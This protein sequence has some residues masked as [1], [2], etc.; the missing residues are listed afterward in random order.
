MILVDGKQ[1][2][3]ALA[4]TFLTSVESP[5]PPRGLYN[6]IAG[7]DTNHLHFREL[8]KSSLDATHSFFSAFYSNN[9]FLFEAFSGDL[10]EDSPAGKYNPLLHLFHLLEE[11]NMLPDIVQEK[12]LKFLQGE[13]HFESAIEGFFVSFKNA[14][15]LLS[16]YSDTESFF[17]QFFNPQGFT[18]TVYATPSKKAR[19][20]G[21]ESQHSLLRKRRM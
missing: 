11:K 21:V 6:S 20:S 3:I 19:G 2:A 18:H 5:P 8:I 10:L 15:T 1:E 13:I 17:N 14:K 12:T 9:S 7:N 4:R 16:C